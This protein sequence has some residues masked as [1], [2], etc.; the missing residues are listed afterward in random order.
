MKRAAVFLGV[1]LGVC[2]IAVG[3]S[4]MAQEKPQDKT[5]ALT[6]RAQSGP[7]KPWKEY[8]TRTLAHLPGFTPGQ[9]VRLSR[10]GGWMDKQNKAT[11]FF[12]A[13]KQEDRWWLFDPEGYA[14]LHVALV[15]LSPGGTKTNKAALQEKFGTREQWA[16]QTVAMV[17]EH[18][19]NGAGAWSDTPLLRQTPAPPVYT[20]IWNFMSAYG[21]KRGGT[22]QQP[23]HTGYPNDCIFVFDPAFESF[24]D[25]LASQLDAT[26]DDPYLLGHFSDNELPFPKDALDRYLALK[27]DDP[28]HQAAQAW[29]K[30]RQ[31]ADKAAITDADR[32]AF[33]E[34]V[35][36]RYFRIT[37]TAIRKHDP[38]H[39]CLGSR[40]H[41]AALGREEVWRAA[42]KYLDVVAVNYYGAWTP[43]ATR[44]AKWEKWAGKPFLVTEWY[45][46]GADAGLKNTGGAGWIVATQPE[47]GLFYQNFALGL[48]QA[49]SCVGWHWFKYM[50]NDPSNLNTDPS[51]RDSNKGVVTIRYEPYTPLLDRMKELNREV[52]PLTAYFDKK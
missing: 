33:L 45:A 42:G 23:G 25:E 20:L 41:G 47:R 16:A 49:K 7:D 28:G 11:G 30:E 38:H 5:K 21:K 10:Y 4:G 15:N 17:R 52:Y 46:K 32:A 29:L 13:Q 40:L 39:L 2:L 48:L 43:D 12:Y 50:D 51:N 22:F 14:F 37:T 6:V 19:F 34:F 8:A 9:V 31:V 1:C 36:D 18:G 3:G 44:M 26:K 24:C 27:E 35:A